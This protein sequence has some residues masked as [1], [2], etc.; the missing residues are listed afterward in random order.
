MVDVRTQYR[1][2]GEALRNECCI[3]AFVTRFGCSNTTRH[4]AC[5]LPV[6]PK[7]DT[8]L[9]ESLD[10]SSAGFRT[11]PAPLGG[12]VSTLAVCKIVRALLVRV[13]HSRRVLTHH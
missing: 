3:A 12:A 10:I 9:I 4:A 5:L 7:P 2:R 1:S 13:T 6:F 8:A 11:L